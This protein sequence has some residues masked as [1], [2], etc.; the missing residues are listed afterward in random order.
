MMDKIKEETKDPELQTFWRK[1]V[2]CF[3]APVVIYLTLLKGHSKWSNY[4]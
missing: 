3:N 4:I 2:E 1:N